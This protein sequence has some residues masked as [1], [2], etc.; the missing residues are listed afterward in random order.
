MGYFAIKKVSSNSIYVRFPRFTLRIETSE[1]PSV[2]N[3]I[4]ESMTT[5]EDRATWLAN[6]YEI[7][8]L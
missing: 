3:S 5:N 6:N 4:L 2:I 1:E 8:Q 7:E